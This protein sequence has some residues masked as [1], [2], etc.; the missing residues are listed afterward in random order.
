[1]MLTACGLVVPRRKLVAAVP[2][3]EHYAA[4]AFAARD[5][6]VASGD[7]AYGAVIVKDGNIV[8]FGPSRVVVNLDPTAHAE[9]EALRH[10]GKTLGTADL[11]GC[12]MYSS[13]PPCRMCETAA[14]WANIERVYSGQP[15]E[16]RG[17]PGYGC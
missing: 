1:M 8:G 13:S 16:D 6:A 10:A 3:H 17:K 4:R 9:M 5:Q 11:T 7:Q 14:Y 2:D 15:A 12:V